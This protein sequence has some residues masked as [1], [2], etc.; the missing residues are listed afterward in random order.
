MKYYLAI[1]AV[2]VITS[3]LRE[4]YAQT[5]TSS[6]DDTIWRTHLNDEAVFDQ[7]DSLSADSPTSMPV[8]RSTFSQQVT[9]ANQRL[10]QLPNGKIVGP[11]AWPNANRVVWKVRI[12]L[13]F[14]PEHHLNMKSILFNC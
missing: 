9:D 3:K 11:T 5:R 8:V 1:M 7:P 2:A 14:Q 6:D 10:F 4:G 12:T 13:L